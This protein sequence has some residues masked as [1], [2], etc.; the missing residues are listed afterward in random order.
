MSHRFWIVVSLFPFVSRN[1]LI[2]SQSH[3][4]L[5]HC[6][7]AWYSI[8][9]ILSV[10]RFFPWDL[11]V[12]SVPYGEKKML[13]MISIFLNLLRLVLCP[14]MWFIFENVPCAFEK[15]V[16]FASLGWKAL[17]IFVKSISSKALF[18]ATISLLIN[19]FRTSVH[20]W[21]WG[22][23]IPYYNCVA[24]NI[25]LEV[26]QDFLYVFGRSYVWS[27]YIYSVDI[28]LLDSSF[29]YYEVNF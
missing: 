5:I 22:T 14:I 19:L 9:V 26:L 6:L 15:N 1:F 8:S 24:V 2:S 23:K 29:E 25:F 7:I 16:Y 17:Y 18:S 13:E 28:F 3:F 12:F 27:T 4:P 20:L 11:F 21:Q 10:L